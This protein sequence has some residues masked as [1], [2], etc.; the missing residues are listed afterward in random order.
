ML[1]TLSDLI[2]G[3]DENIWAIALIF[4]GIAFAGMM[5]KNVASFG[6]RYVRKRRGPS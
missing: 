2:A 3:G 5:L 4:L 6:F 1:K